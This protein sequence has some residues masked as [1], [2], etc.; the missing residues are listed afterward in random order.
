MEE[1]DDFNKN[2]E[3]TRSVQKKFVT[4]YKQKILFI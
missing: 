2:Y 3:R 1:K 4:K